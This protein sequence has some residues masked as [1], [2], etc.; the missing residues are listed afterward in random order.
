MSFI[1]IK[2]GSGGVELTEPEPVSYPGGVQW[3]IRHTLGS[4]GCWYEIWREE[5][6]ARKR[7]AQER[8]ALRKH[9][10]LWPELVCADIEWKVAK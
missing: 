10:E 1:C 9:P 5:A 2:F 7:L 6:D 3:A 4:G 8:D